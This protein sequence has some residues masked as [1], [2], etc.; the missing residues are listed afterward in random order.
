[1][2]FKIKIE[3]LAKRDIQNEI[4]YYNSRQKDLGKKF[5]AELKDYLKALEQTP[6]YGIR[7]DSVHCLPLK[8]FPVMIHYT[9]DELNKIIVV[10]AVINTSKN[11][12]TYWLK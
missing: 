9:L 1:M 12:D 11:P 8:K 2:E 4:N 5:H 10:R 6:F 3:P 7:Y